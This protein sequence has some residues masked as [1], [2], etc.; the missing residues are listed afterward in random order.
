MLLIRKDIPP[1]F[2]TSKTKTEY[3]KALKFIDEENIYDLLYES[4]YKSIIKSSSI[5]VTNIN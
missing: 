3:K 5:Y 2:F 1:I 4:F